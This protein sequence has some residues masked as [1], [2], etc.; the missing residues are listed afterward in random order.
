MLKLWTRSSELMD[1]R[2]EVKRSALSRTSCPGRLQHFADIM[3]QHNITQ[4][5][6]RQIICSAMV[7]L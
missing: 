1:V 2:R 7:N 6:R 3:A 4:L 5:K